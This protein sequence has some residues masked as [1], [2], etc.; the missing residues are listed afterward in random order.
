MLALVIANLKIMVRDRQTLFWAL[1]FPLIFVIIFGLFDF[2]QSSTVDLA[3][4]DQANSE[5]SRELSRKLSETE[6]LKVDARY[7]SRIE[8]QEALRNGDLE[9]LL[10]IPES[11]EAPSRGLASSQGNSAPVSLLL[12]QGTGNEAGNQLVAETIRRSVDEENLRLVG[13]P[14]LLELRTEMVKAPKVDYFDLVLIGL[15]GMSMMMNCIIVIAVKISLYRSQSV[16]KRLLATPLR[17]RNYF[18]S[19]IAAHVL[20]SLVQTAVVIGVG[21][22]VFGATIH[23]NVL[24]VFIIVAFASIIFLNIGFIISAWANS[25]SAASG[26][27]NA[28]AMPMLFLSGTFFPTSSLPSFLPDLVQALPLTPVLDAMRGVAIDGLGLW[29]VGRELGMLAGWVV[30]SSL[31]AVKLFRFG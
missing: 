29:N 15:V 14:K 17:V 13:A 23:G 16:L 22:Y 28:V 19:E 26:M 10:I 6:H 25:P 4:I 2:E 7:A 3:I 20:L 18:A 30:V 24:W 27:G 12:Y 8:A 1:V 5:G 31:A 9:N 11:A 21:V